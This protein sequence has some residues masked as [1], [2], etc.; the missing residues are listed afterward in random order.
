MKR[1]Y[2]FE[3]ELSEKHAK[4]FLSNQP[5]STKYSTELCRELKGKKLGKAMAKLERLAQ[6]KEFLPLRMYNK[7]IPHRKGNAVSF[8]KSGRYPI[9]TAQ[10]FKRLLELVKANADYKGMDEE[11]LKII[12]MFAS[13]GYGRVSHQPK[14]KTSGKRRKKKSTHI[15][16]I[17]KETK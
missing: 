9:R 12:H 16:I 4:A 3:E 15:E 17:V 2:N 6:K 14:G 13:Q 10:T 8:V 11:N 1:H 7:K 5:I